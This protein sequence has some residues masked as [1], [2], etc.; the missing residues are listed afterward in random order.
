MKF[1]EFE[2][3]VI[4]FALNAQ[5][6]LEMEQIEKMENEGQTPIMTKDY[7]EHLFNQMKEKVKQNTKTSLAKQK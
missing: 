3:M 7:M 5:L 2:K 1:T 6:K 4:T